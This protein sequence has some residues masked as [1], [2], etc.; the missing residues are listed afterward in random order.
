MVHRLM[1]FAIDPW[2]AENK[3]ILSVTSKILGLKNVLNFFLVID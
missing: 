3:K 1:P 2:E